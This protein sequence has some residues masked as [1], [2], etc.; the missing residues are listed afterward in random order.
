MQMSVVVTDEQFTKLMEQFAPYEN[1]PIIAI[2]VSGGSDSMALSFLASRWAKA[3]GGRA[4]ALTV[5]HGLRTESAEEARTV[6]LWMQQ[7]GMEHKVLN[8]VGEKPKT[9]IHEAA[10]QARYDLLSNECE[11]RGIRHLLIAHTM[12]DQAETVV[13][14]LC[15][16]SGPDGLAGMSQVR[17]MQHGRLLRPLLGV[18]REALKETCRAAEL[19]WV[20]DKSN[21]S[22]K[23]TRA[24]VRKIMQLLEPEGFTKENL[25]MTAG[26]C[27]SDRVTYESLVSEFMAKNVAVYPEGW[28]KIDFS[29]LR[30]QPRALL[31]RII[32]RLTMIIGGN[33]RAP[34]MEKLENA[35]DYIYAGRSSAWTLGGCVF[36]VRRGELH[37]CRELAAVAAPVELKPGETVIWDGRFRVSL[38]KDAG[39]GFTLKAV[40]G[41]KRVQERASGIRIPHQVLETM[42][43]LWDG[44][45]L[46]YVPGI[47]D[48]RDTKGQPLAEVSLNGFPSLASGRGA[49]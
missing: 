18:S 8:W 10:R 6:G 31:M 24:R 47:I 38:S 4:L 9:G 44:G 33:D 41:G 5:D 14:R 49:G 43:S 46:V 34:R 26:R 29:A 1:P 13:M 19:S 27:A 12:D 39:K 45:K 15:K 22:D 42:P 23:F 37:V 48:A 36:F 30:L 28:C 3:R 21:Y 17:L 16:G 40:G 25:V 35:A 11:Q 2:G 20:D 32:A 7:L